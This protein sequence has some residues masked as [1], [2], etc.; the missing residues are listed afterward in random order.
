MQ[1]FTDDNDDDDDDS[2]VMYVCM[3]N[4]VTCYIVVV[5]CFVDNITHKSRK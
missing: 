4:A 1:F 2:D 5:L 3:Y